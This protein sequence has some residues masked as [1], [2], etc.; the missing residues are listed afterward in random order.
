MIKKA[1]IAL[2]A[3][4]VLFF[5][6]GLVFGESEYVFPPKYQEG[7]PSIT[8]MPKDD[9]NTNKKGTTGDI[10]CYAFGPFEDEKI[11]QVIGNRVN[12]LGL[13][14][15]I[16]KQQ[17]KQ[18]LNFLVYLEPFESRNA[19]LEVIKEIRKHEVKQHTILNSGPYKNAIALGSFTNLD[20]ARRHAEYIRFLGFDARHVKQQKTNFVYWVNYNEPFGQ[21][22]PVIAW[23]EE[24]DEKNSPQK[25]PKTCT[26]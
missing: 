21:N 18:T 23:A 19:A 3:L 10:S 11:A 22:I 6:G 14:T 26:R 4:N 9:E 13:W 8:L 7:I 15:N 1:I 17:T 5:I 12:G 2:V 16:N 25:I 20:D 24:A